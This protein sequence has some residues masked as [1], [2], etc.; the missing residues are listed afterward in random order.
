M[1]RESEYIKWTG[2]KQAGWMSYKNRQKF[3]MYA[4]TVL[5]SEQT[6]SDQYKFVFQTMHIQ[7]VSSLSVPFTKV[8]TAQ[9]FP[10]SKRPK[11]GRL[12]LWE[13]W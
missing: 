9:N 11:V 10:L 1:T 5:Y 6:R 12:E 4:N 7:N 3:I 13:L 8:P 2:C